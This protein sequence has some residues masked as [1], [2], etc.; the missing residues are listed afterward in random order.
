MMSENYFVPGFAVFNRG[1]VLDLARWR[2][3]PYGEVVCF[4]SWL[5]VSALCTIP[6][7]VGAAD[8]EPLVRSTATA[9]P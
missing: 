3:A 9:C 5:C 7:L 1:W 4:Y 2:F 6:N 8:A